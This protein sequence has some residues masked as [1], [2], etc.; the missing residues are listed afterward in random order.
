MPPVSAAFPQP[1]GNL[2]QPDR[3]IGQTQAF[4][5]L[6]RNGVPSGRRALPWK[7]ALFCDS[8]HPHYCLILIICSRPMAR[9]KWVTGR[10]EQ[11]PVVDGPLLKPPGLS[12]ENGGVGN[13]AA[14]RFGCREICGCPR[15]ASH[16]RA[17]G[18]VAA[19]AS[20]WY[21][22]L[23]REIPL[24][25]CCSFFFDTLA[26]QFMSVNQCGQRTPEPDRMGAWASHNA[27]LKTD[28]R[29]RGRLQVRE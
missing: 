22:Q 4:F 20:G 5:P 12:V 7:L 6:K 27:R 18:E 24:Q 16:S 1:L 15:D 17:L 9:S 10:S 2:L 29:P 13:L 28:A 25:I 23:K 14:A 26:M 8:E 3:D 11:V 21:F 19:T